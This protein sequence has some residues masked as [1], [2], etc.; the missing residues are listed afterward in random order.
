[1]RIAVV[2]D[3]DDTLCDESDTGRS[4]FHMSSDLAMTLSDA[5]PERT[6]D[7]LGNLAKAPTERRFFS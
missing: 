2:F 4:G 3:L 6:I 5:R 1:M 7:K